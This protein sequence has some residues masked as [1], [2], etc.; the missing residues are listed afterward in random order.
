[1]T[2]GTIETENTKFEYQ[3]KVD[4]IID[5]LVKTWNDKDIPIEDWGYVPKRVFTA[6][7]RHVTPYILVEYS[8]GLAASKAQEQRIHDLEAEIEKLKSDRDALKQ[9]YNEVSKMDTD[10][11]ELLLDQKGDIGKLQK[12][13][14]YLED[15]IET[16][17]RPSSLTK[18]EAKEAYQYCGETDRCPIIDFFA[19]KGV[20]VSGNGTG[21][22][23][24]KE[25]WAVNSFGYGKSA[26]KSD[27][28]RQ[29][30]G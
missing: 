10:K 27:S 21:G 23:K 15:E 5:G 14:K 6:L 30:D 8:K 18:E 11:A 24:V 3:K 22:N 28:K 9:A 29:G 16:L 7:I 17:K 13:I 1:M 25:K 26:K 20:D 19:K 12:R 4:N 2:A